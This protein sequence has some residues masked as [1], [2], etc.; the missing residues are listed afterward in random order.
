[1]EIFGKIIC[2]LPIR[3]GVSAKSGKPWQSAT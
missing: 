2:A 3:Y 1:M